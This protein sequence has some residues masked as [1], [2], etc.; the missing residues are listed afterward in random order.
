MLLLSVDEL[1]LFFGEPSWTMVVLPVE[2]L[3]SVGKLVGFLHGNY[4]I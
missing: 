3:T 1:K 2:F 4:K